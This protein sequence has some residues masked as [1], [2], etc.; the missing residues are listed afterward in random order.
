MPYNEKS[1]ENISNTN[2]AVMD[3][4]K[5]REIARKGAYAMLEKRREK[6][7]LKETTKALLE[8]SIS[9]EYAEKT[10][11]KENADLI[12]DNELTMQALLSV[13]LASALLQDGNAKAFELLRD[14][15]GQKP[16][17][18]LEINAD[19]MTAADR[20]LLDKINA[21]MTAGNDPDG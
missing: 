20:A 11:G 12:P 4:D 13:R 2:F 1:L 6:K 18:E 5:Q 7:T 14:T 15:S 16:K 21:R 3:K 19:I 8:T 17:D 9:R 10:I